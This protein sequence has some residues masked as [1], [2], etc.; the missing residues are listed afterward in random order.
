MPKKTAA[1]KANKESRSTQHRARKPSQGEKPGKGRDSGNKIQEIKIA[2]AVKSRD[3]C[4]PKLSMLFLPFVAA[5]V[6][7]FL[8]A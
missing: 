8:R 6:Y 5:G 2:E 7:L 4:F 1:H 3:G